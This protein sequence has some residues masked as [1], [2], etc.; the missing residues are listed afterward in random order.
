MRLGEDVD[1]VWR[2]VDA[3]HRCR[4]EPATVVHHEA[5]PT[6][7]ALLRQ[8]VGYGR[9]AAPLSRRHPRA[10]APLRMSGWS[11][12][13]W[14]LVAA[15]RP[16]LALGLAGGTTVALQRKLHDV[17]PADAARLAARGHLAAGRQ[18]AQAIVRVWWPIALVAACVCRRARLPVA[19]AFVA[20]AVIDAVRSRSAQPLLDA[21]LGTIEQMAYG[22]GVW[23][24]AVAERTPGP[25]LPEL[26]NWPPRTA[27]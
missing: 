2:L 3:G 15:R 5:R 23:A 18:W 24:G 13:V 1:L 10:L 14:L 17:P 8:R 27:G 4:Y 11:A 16:L 22:A 20:P 26:R 25:L 12:A 6:V 19:A 7:A 9:S 21:P